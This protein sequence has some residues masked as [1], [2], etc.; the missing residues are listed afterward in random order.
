[1]KKWLS[2]FSS[3]LLRPMLYQAMRRGIIT[4]TA[5]LLWDR[6]LGGG[7]PNGFVNYTFA[8]GMIFLLLAWSKYLSMDGLTFH[9]MLEEKKS[10]KKKRH[11]TRDMVD[12]VDEHVTNFDE[13][14]EDEQKLCGFLSSLL[15]MVIFFLASMIASCF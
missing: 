14:T 1:M 8:A 13:L 4:V 15:L 12:F 10:P 9:Y 2:V 11:F 5:L 3:V 7:S 6:F